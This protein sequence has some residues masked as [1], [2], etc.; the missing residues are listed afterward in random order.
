M[1]QII[2]QIDGEIAELCGAL[3]DYELFTSLPAAGPTYAPRL[4]AAFGENRDRFQ[5]ARRV[6]QCSGVAPVL[7]RSGKKSWVHWRYACSTS[8]R[9]RFVALLGE[10]VCYSFWA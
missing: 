8:M 1:I 9:Q 7:E 2:K 4:L 5:S 10:T 6:Q 3:E